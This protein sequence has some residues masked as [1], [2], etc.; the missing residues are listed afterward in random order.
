MVATLVTVSASGR[1]RHGSDVA[2]D[3]S[4]TGNDVVRGRFPGRNRTNKSTGR[5]V[6]TMGFVSSGDSEFFGGAGNDGGAKASV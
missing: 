1:K 3:S 4:A 5:F 2:A 6:V